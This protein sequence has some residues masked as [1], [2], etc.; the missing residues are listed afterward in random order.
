MPARW[1]LQEEKK[2]RKELEDLYIEKKKTI[3]E[4]A[5][6][7]GMSWQGVY[8]RIQRLEIEVDPTRKITY[9]CKKRS[10]H[11]GGAI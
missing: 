10:S 7:L 9:R 4:I 5:E 8:S 1:T 11:L 2:K 6:V 3:F